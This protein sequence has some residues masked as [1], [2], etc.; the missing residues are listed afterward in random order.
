MPARSSSSSVRIWPD[1]ATVDKAVRDW[2]RRTAARKPE[3]VRIGYFGSYARG[4]WGLGSDVDLL[5][6]VDRA[7]QP[8]E[9]RSAH[10]DATELPVPA[11]ALIYTLA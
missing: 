11:E 10:W 4:N 7:D 5:I 8:F 3:T 2:A 1:A 6:I 9:R